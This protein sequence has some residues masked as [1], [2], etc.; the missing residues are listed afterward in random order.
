MLRTG[1][2]VDETG[3]KAWKTPFEVE[4]GKMSTTF[5]GGKVDE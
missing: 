1:D 2:E 5:K 4:S 3:K